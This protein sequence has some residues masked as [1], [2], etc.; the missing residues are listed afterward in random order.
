VTYDTCH[1]VHCEQACICDKS[2][3][4]RTLLLTTM[5]QHS[6]RSRKGGVW[7]GKV[8][9]YACRGYCM[10]DTGWLEIEYTEA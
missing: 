6:R 1:Y 9:K 3:L 10:T 8:E 7:I 5:Q 2:R 4:Y